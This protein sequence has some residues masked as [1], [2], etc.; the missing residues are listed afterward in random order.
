MGAAHGEWGQ[1]AHVGAEHGEWG[2]RAHVGAAHGEWGQRAHVGVAL[3]IEWRQKQALLRE[4]GRPLCEPASSF[5]E[6]DG[7]E[8]GRE[9]GVGWMQLQSQWR[10]EC[11]DETPASESEM[12]DG[13]E[14]EGGVRGLLEGWWGEGLQCEGDWEAIDESNWLEGSQRVKGE[15]GEGAREAQSE[16]RCEQPWNTSLRQDGWQEA[17]WDWPQ[18]LASGPGDSGP[19]PEH[20]WEGCPGN[21]NWC[22]GVLGFGEERED[23][24]E[25]RGGRETEGGWEVGGED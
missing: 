2:Q 9:E 17:S 23:C 13:E 8:E 19:A 15:E 6:E 12:W 1:R 25:E 22:E 24:V 11:Q 5:G 16:D 7:E 3:E 10:V 4:Q 21:C 18:G 14:E 20:S